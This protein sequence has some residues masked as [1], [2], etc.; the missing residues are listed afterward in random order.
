MTSFDIFLTDKFGRCPPFHE[1]VNYT[2]VAA[3]VQCFT[4]SDC[5]A[6]VCNTASCMD[7]VCVQTPITCEPSNTC[8][9][10]GVCDLD[11]GNCT[12]PRRCVSDLCT[13]RECDA[14]HSRCVETQLVTCNNIHPCLT[15]TCDITSGNCSVGFVQCP[16]SNECEHATCKLH[17]SK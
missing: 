7:G 9:I 14:R 2:C 12:N 15:N 17:Q 10:A 4:D 1:C 16:R 11:T 5:N 6:S 13:R 3:S 8:H